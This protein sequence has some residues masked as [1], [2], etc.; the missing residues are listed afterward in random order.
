MPSGKQRGLAGS[1]YY[2]YDYPGFRPTSAH[3]WGI[4]ITYL[5]TV[6]RAIAGLLMLDHPDGKR[7]GTIGGADL[8]PAAWSDR[9]LCRRSLQ[10][11]DR[12][13]TSRTGLEP[14]KGRFPHVGF[15]F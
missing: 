13:Q 6:Q 5:H 2:Y 12:F 15:F 8:P 14:D 3:T 1:I 7:N 9:P 11:L 10:T 4:N